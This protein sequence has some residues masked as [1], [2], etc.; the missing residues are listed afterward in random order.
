MAEPI[1]LESARLHLRRWRDEDLPALAALS[2]DPEVMR[3]FPAPLG[4]DESAALLGR[5]RAHFDEHGFGLWALERR[6]SGEL[7]G[8]TGLLKVSFEVHFAPA[9]EIG[10][11]LARMHWGQGLASEAA[12]AALACGFGRLGLE[13]IVSF[14]TTG[15][16]PSRRVME[17]IGMRRDPAGDFEHPLISAGHPLRPHVLYRLRRDEW[18]AA[19]G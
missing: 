11:R 15:N 3:H 18:E 12:R 9:V 7:I 13:E 10:W 4:Q 14:T 19:H 8:F 17:A 1:E 16:Q 5:I 6:D 2:A